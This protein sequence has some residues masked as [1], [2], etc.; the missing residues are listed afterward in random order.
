MA[1]SMGRVQLTG[2][3]LGGHTEDGG[4]A[5]VVQ[6]EDQDPDLLAA[7]EPGA[8]MWGTLGGCGAPSSG[9][10]EESFDWGSGT[11]IALFNS[12]FRRNK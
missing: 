5:G 2:R 7:E 9:P 8:G 12:L 11:M 10:S 1:G 3:G 6:A 4:L